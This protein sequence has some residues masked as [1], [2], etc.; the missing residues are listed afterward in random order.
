MMAAAT[1]RLVTDDKK[2]TESKSVGS[3]TH[4]PIETQ[5][6]AAQQLAKLADSFN[7]LYQQPIS[8]AMR[9]LVVTPAFADLQRSITASPAL[10]NLHRQISESIRVNHTLTAQTILAARVSEQVQSALQPQIREL[11]TIAAEQLAAI[12]ADVVAAARA[13]IT[14]AIRHSISNQSVSRRVYEVAVETVERPA[15]EVTA[16]QEW[17][18]PGV[19]IG[20]VGLLL[21]FLAAQDEILENAGEDVEAVM[22]LLDAVREWTVTLLAWLHRLLP[23]S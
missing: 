22:E 10:D 23:P 11:S 9:G 16:R 18:K 5:L 8:E 2:A 21:A 15:E 20:L 7:R 12:N 1:L 4:R 3:R 13:S 6:L 14:Q 19:V 17:T